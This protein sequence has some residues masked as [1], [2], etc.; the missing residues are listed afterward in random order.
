M[1]WQDG[2]RLVCCER[3]HRDIS[4]SV[5]PRFTLLT[6]DQCTTKLLSE[7][8]ILRYT[9]CVGDHGRVAVV[10]CAVSTVRVM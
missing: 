7:R 8:H 4:I 10:W 3:E 2:S 5:R 1:L 9:K 6:R